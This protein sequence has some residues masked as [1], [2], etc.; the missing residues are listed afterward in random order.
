MP[1]LQP[2]PRGQRIPQYLFKWWKLQLQAMERIRT[3]EGMSEYVTREEFDEALLEVHREIAE[4][5][6]RMTMNDEFTVGLYYILWRKFR[7]IRAEL[8]AKLLRY[9]PVQFSSSEL[10]EEGFS[11]ET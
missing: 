11:V 1:I 5:R 9:I 2:V 4:D 3:G 10:Q 7:S 8:E 6:K